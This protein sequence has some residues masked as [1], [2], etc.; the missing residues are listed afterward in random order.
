MLILTLWSICV[1]ILVPE[2]AWRGGVVKGSPTASDREQQD[3]VRD[4]TAAARARNG[5][6][7]FLPS[8]AALQGAVTIA[9]DAASRWEPKIAAGIRAALDFAAD[10]PGAAAALTINARRSSSS[11]GDREREVIS[12]FA[13]M[14]GKVTPDEMRFPI[15]T[16][17]GVVE[18]IAITVRGHLLAG[19]ESELP[20]LAPELTYLALMPYTGLAG[21]RRWSERPVL[22]KRS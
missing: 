3:E 10:D 22:T 16:D 15:S 7:Q 5:T 6:T 8:F 2:T 18:S 4:L 11:Q 12:H 1:P 20:A 13:G 9:C 21:A 17:E 14:L 19:I